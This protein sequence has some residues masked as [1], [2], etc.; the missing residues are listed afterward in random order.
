MTQG[1]IANGRAI[2]QEELAGL[3]MCRDIPLFYTSTVC[4]RTR[5]FSM[6]NKGLDCGRIYAE[7]MHATWKI[8]HVSDRKNTGNPAKIRE[9]LE[10][11]CLSRDFSAKCC[12][13]NF[14]GKP[15]YHCLHMDKDTSFVPLGFAKAK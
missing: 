12:L 7:S 5:L 3:V 6:K 8:K 14:L 15:I 9:T 2:A 11:Q 13:K 1:N 10:M 4:W